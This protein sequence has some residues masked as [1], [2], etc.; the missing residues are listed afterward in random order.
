MRYLHEFAA[1]QPGLTA[2]Q[3]NSLLE[4]APAALYVVETMLEMLMYPRTQSAFSRHSPSD[5]TPLTL[6]STGCKY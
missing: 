1:L 2:A 5:R 3:N 4:K 6:N